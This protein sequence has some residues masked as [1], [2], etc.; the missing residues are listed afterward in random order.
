MTSS[1][2]FRI[3]DFEHPAMKTLRAERNLLP[4]TQLFKEAQPLLAFP[5]EQ[6]NKRNKASN[7]VDAIFKLSKEDQVR[8]MELRNVQIFDTEMRMFLISNIWTKEN[9]DFKQIS[10]IASIYRFNC[11]EFAD[12]SEAILHATLLHSQLRARI[13]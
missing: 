11:F 3:A 6:R 1:Q 13:W 5:K 2:L 4:G 7:V 10:V 8:Y 9:I 12:G